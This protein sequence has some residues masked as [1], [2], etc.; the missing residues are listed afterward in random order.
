LA[1][2]DEMEFWPIAENDLEECCTSPSLP[3][4]APPRRATWMSEA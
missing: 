3:Q 1:I 4:Q 2:G